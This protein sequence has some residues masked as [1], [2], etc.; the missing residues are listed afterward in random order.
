M[1]SSELS[2]LGP[3]TDSAVDLDEPTQMLNEA[4]AHHPTAELD[5][6]K[7]PEMYAPSHT[8]STHTG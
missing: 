8:A 2:G 7:L 3:H 6:T 5:V 4:R 1:S